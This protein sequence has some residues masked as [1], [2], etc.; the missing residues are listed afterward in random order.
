[1]VRGRL[2]ERMSGR[3]ADMSGANGCVNT[4]R[5]AVESKMIVLGEA[6]GDVLGAPFPRQWSDAEWMKVVACLTQDVDMQW[7]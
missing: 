3:V 7:L 5:E 6:V 1:M 2:E 4:F